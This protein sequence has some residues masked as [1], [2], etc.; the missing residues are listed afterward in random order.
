M[1]SE[2]HRRVGQYWT[3]DSATE[4]ENPRLVILSPN[5]SHDRMEDFTETKPLDIGPMY[6]FDQMK[7]KRRKWEKK[8]CLPHLKHTSEDKLSLPESIHPKELDKKARQPIEAA[9]KKKYAFQSFAISPTPVV[10]KIPIDIKFS[11]IRRQKSPFEEF[12]QTAAELL[13]ELGETLQTYAKNNIA[14]PVGIVNL[15]NYSWLDL[16]EGTYK[17]ATKKSLSKKQNVLQSNSSSMMVDKIN[18]PRIE[19]HKENYLMKAKKDRHHFVPIEKTC[20]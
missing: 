5:M 1:K 14:F 4:L 13:C 18:Y 2:E 10:S 16:I 3:L 19:C 9:L 11:K 6:F 7:P 12:K 15:V 17:Y 20:K 8:D